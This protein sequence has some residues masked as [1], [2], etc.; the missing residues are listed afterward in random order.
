[1]FSEVLISLFYPENGSSISSE[2]PIYHFYIKV[3]GSMFP[4]PP[5]PFLTINASYFPE[6]MVSPKRLHGVTATKSEK[7]PS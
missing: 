7:L 5:V 3:G 1:M 6:I 2:V 4:P